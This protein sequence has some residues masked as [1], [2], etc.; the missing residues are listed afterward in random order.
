MAISLAS[1]AVAF[2]L[3]VGSFSTPAGRIWEPWAERLQC[4]LSDA[5]MLRGGVGEMGDCRACSSTCVGP[6]SDNRG[7]T[8]VMASLCF[9]LFASPRRFL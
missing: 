9:D 3:S 7:P 5:W 8:F 4:L 6:G 1:E 2:G